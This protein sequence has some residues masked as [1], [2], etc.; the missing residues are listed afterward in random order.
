MKSRLLSGVAGS[1]ASICSLGT[2][3]LYHTKLSPYIHPGDF[4]ISSV[5]LEG[6]TLSPASRPSAFRPL[7]SCLSFVFGYCVDT[8]YALAA[9]YGRGKLHFQTGGFGPLKLALDVANRMKQESLACVDEKSAEDMIRRIGEP[10][11]QW[12][13]EWTRHAE[14]KCWVRDGKFL[15][16]VCRMFE[17][18]VIDA[19]L[20][21]ESKYC[22]FRYVLPPSCDPTIIDEAQRGDQIPLVLHLPCSGDQYYEWRSKHFAYPIANENI[23]SII[24]ISPFYGPRQI[25]NR[26]IRGAQVNRVSDLITYGICLLPES[27]S[28]LAHLKATMPEHR[29]GKVTVCGISMGAEMAGLLAAYSP[30]PF[31]VLAVAPA[32]NANSV[33]QDGVL[34]H[35][36]AW[37]T[38]EEE[39]KC[40][41]DVLWIG[42]K[43]YGSAKDCVSAALETTSLYAFPSPFSWLPQ[44]QRPKSIVIGAIHDAYIPL[45]SIQHVANVW[46][47]NNVS[48]R[49]ILGG[50]ATLVVTH[51][52]L[53]RHCIIELCK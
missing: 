4:G 40:D 3:Y 38:L 24:L 39:G 52:E 51:K 22:Y 19:L 53:I 6:E 42:T 26:P 28:L 31:N 35:V 44:D 21:E 43:S 46:R 5:G 30:F 34:A 10:D 45:N 36:V 2:F 50:H 23:G 13:G 29:D 32:H 1:V 25:P 16:P 9:G 17:A 37:D 18:S 8:G 47:N 41:E 48:L 27:V 49:W 15:S 7:L 14:S 11:I 20:N 33:W 12:K